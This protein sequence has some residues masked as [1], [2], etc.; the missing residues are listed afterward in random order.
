MAPPSPVPARTVSS[1]VITG[2]APAVGAT[3]QFT[4]T[5]TLS[6]GTTQNVTTQAAWQSSNPAVVTVSGSGVVT[7]VGIGE[8]DVRASYQSASGTQHLRHSFTSLG[9][10]TSSRA[11]NLRLR[12]QAPTR[13]TRSVTASWE[14]VTSMGISLVEQHYL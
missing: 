9:V 4:A 1:I 8:A 3:S 11:A 5:A 14:R 2:T 10:L 7:G 13:T 12:H 6:D